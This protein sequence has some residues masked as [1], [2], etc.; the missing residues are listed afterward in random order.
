M[1]KVIDARV[2]EGMTIRHMY[3]AFHFGVPKNTLAGI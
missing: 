2:N 3:T 1:E